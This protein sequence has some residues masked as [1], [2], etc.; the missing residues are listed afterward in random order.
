MLDM[1]KNIYVLEENWYVFSLAEVSRESANVKDG[2]WER[3][4]KIIYCV[5]LQL[6][7]AVRL[8]HLQG[9]GGSCM[10]K[11]KVVH[12]HYYHYYYCK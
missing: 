7:R 8:S 9:K 6:F 2:K 10:H 1:E 3:I 4:R 5:L 12:A 11:I